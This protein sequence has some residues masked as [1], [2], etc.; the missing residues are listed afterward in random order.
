MSSPSHSG[1]TPSVNTCTQA[2]PLQEES[3]MLN[4]YEQGTL[5]VTSPAEVSSSY[6]TPIDLPWKLD[7]LNQ[8]GHPLQWNYPYLWGMEMGYV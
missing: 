3:S 1:H 2:Q 5:R 4:L 7:T 8:S 6:L